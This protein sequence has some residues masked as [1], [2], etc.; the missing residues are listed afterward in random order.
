MK[1][2]L[3]PST[4]VLILTSIQVLMILF[5][6]VNMFL[7]IL[8]M[9]HWLGAILI[10]L[11]GYFLIKMPVSIFVDADTITVNQLVGNV[12]F[13]RRM[14]IVRRLKDT[15]TKSIV[16]VFGSGGMGGYTGYFANAALGSFKMYAVSTKNLCL[17]TDPQQ[18]KYVINLPVGI[19]I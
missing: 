10:I 17:I 16:R 3:K 15:E 19:E 4:F 11:L 12:K 2:N 1:K 13:D 8:Y 5:L 18:K 7:S 14:C 9:P 6:I